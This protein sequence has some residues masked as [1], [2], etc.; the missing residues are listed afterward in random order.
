[1]QMLID[2]V[3]FYDSFKSYLCGFYVKDFVN[4]WTLHVYGRYWYQIA[5]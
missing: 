2:T 3:S 4:F 5:N 1:M